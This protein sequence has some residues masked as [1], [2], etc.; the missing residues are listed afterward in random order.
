MFPATRIRVAELG[1]DRTAH[2]KQG[3]KTTKIGMFGCCYESAQR[4]EW[5]HH[6]AP[7]SRL[8]TA[9]STQV[10]SDVQ[11]VIAA[12]HRESQARAAHPFR[13]PVA[14][15]RATNAGESPRQRSK[16]NPPAR[17]VAR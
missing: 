4:G 14:R 10:A 7:V 3:R 2:R 13:V 15:A 11:M 5:L 9:P 1:A 17:T 16:M 8:P 6:G 12:Q